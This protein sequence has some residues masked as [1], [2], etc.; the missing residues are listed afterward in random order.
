MPKPV[1]QR[2][3]ALGFDRCRW[4][5]EWGFYVIL[6]VKNWAE[7]QHYKDRSPPWIKMHRELL[8]NMEYALLSP[9]AG[10]ALP[11][12]WL[13]ASEYEGGLPEVRHLAFRLRTTPEQAQAIANELKAAGFLCDANSPEPAE[14]VATPAQA[15]GWGSRHISD[16]VKRA[17]W[18]RDKGVCCHCQ[19]PENIEYDHVIPVSRGGSSTLENIQLLCR[20]CNR[21]KR[22][23]LATHAQTLR[24]PET[25]TEERACVTSDDVLPAK[26]KREQI[27]TRL[28]DDWQPDASLTEWAATERPDLN[29]AREIAGFRD[30][31]HSRAGKDARKASWPLT[32]RNWIRNSRNGSKPQTQIGGSRAAGRLL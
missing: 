24:S 25:E 22:N 19:S 9:E 32:F 30:Y 13:I 15:A 20:G 16:K 12:I 1:A 11:L 10:K 31:W 2:T 5:S 17:A 23:S 18:A 7:F 4:G 8:D 3:G 27:G 29:L 6:T 21:K 26:P 14:R 28:P